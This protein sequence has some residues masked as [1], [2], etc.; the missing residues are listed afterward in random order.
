MAIHVRFEGEVAILSGVARLMNDP[1]H[2]DSARDVG[3]LLDQGYRRFVLEMANVR[4][5]GSTVLGLM[6]TLT[7]KVRKAEGEVVLAN[8]APSMAKFLDE[9]RMDDFWD[10][11]DH[12]DE[13]VAFL[14]RRRMGTTAYE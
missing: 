6:T 14:A 13:A 11:F 12:A 8:L 1:R 3:D 5:T 2:F 10:V 4:E 7:R 9:M